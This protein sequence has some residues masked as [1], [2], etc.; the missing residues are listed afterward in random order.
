MNK[1]DEFMIDV[2]KPDVVGITES[3]AS[4]EVDDAGLGICVVQNR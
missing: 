2:L 3:W 4:A 1:V